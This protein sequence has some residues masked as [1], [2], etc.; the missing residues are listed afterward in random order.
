MIEIGHIGNVAYRL[1]VIRRFLF[2]CVQIYTQNLLMQIY[3]QKK[4]GQYARTFKLNN[5]TVF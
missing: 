1:L 3:I 4:Y 2:W 5:K